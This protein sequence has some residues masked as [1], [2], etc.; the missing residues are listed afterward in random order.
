MDSNNK[1]NI[2]NN[3]IDFQNGG[4]A[5]MMAFCHKHTTNMINV[6]FCADCYKALLEKPL[7]EMAYSCCLNIDFG[8]G[9]TE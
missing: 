5:L 1:C 9:D 4:A 7:R 3:E 6:S 2:C 8:D